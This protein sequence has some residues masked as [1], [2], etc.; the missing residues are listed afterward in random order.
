M[1]LGSIFL[2]P[3]RRLKSD[4]HKL[5]RELIEEDIRNGIVNPDRALH[6]LTQRLG[7]LY[8]TAPDDPKIFSTTIHSRNGVCKSTSTVAER[9]PNGQNQNVTFPPL[10][11]TI[12]SSTH[13]HGGKYEVTNT[14]NPYQ[15]AIQATVSH[16][17]FNMNTPKLWPNPQS[18]DCYASSKF[19][20][21][22]KYF[23]SSPLVS[24]R[25][26]SKSHTLLPPSIRVSKT[27]ALQQTLYECG[28][29][30]RGNILKETELDDKAENALQHHR[31]TL[32]THIRWLDDEK[33]LIF[34]TGNR[35]ETFNHSSD[36]SVSSISTLSGTGKAIN[37]NKPRIP[38]I[39]SLL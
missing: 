31:N 32:R 15:P 24:D 2:P 26:C 18:Y 11:A 1:S 7:R 37:S 25:P 38:C 3:E 29:L 30:K 20:E 22:E 36:R 12:L 17:E 19:Q 14:F 33:D 4:I 35:S 9:I 21:N 8:N 5:H 13:T 27:S 28:K 34:P 10:T 16:S 23:T 6:D 39:T